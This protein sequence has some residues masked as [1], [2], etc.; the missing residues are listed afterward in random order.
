MA[1][2]LTE[3]LG[4]PVVVENIS[5][6]SG[7]IGTERVAK[8][9]PDGYTL[10]ISA[11][12]PLVVNQSLFEA[13][14]R[15]DPGF[16][17]DLATL[18]H[19][20]RPCGQQRRAGKDGAGADRAGA[21]KPG[22]I[23]F[24]SVTPVSASISAA[25]CSSRGRHRDAAGALSRRLGVGAGYSRRRLPSLPQHPQ[26]AAAGAGG[27]VAR[28][29]RRLAET[30][31]GLPGNADDG[32]GRESAASKRRRGLADGARRNPKV[33]SS[34]GCTG[35]PPRC[36]PS[37]C[38]GKAFEED[39]H[40]AL[41]AI[42]LR[43]STLISRPEPAMGKVISAV[44]SNPDAKSAYC[45]ATSAGGC[46]SIAM[47]PG[48]R[49]RARARRGSPGTSQIVVAEMREVGVGIE[50]DVGDGVALGGEEAV[51]A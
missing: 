33:R 32:G 6:A 5:G 22:K 25:N 8:S 15:P 44:A 28:A 7:N 2:K 3:A 37:R 49:R 13:A 47:W 39:G 34:N 27:E 10:L 46:Q 11:P 1:D 9:A 50:R 4:K 14:L 43:N 23:F 31:A 18:L 35:R 51:A 41:S 36:S 17:S 40:T 42:R 12:G 26:G 19:A 16:C 48:W 45:A 24:A 21:Q 20:Q 30:L 38:A 29:R